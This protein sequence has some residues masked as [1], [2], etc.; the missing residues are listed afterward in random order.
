M[1]IYINKVLTMFWKTKTDII[2]HLTLIILWTINKLWIKFKTHK[3]NNK[4]KI[5]WRKI[6][7]IDLNVEVRVNQI[8]T[9]FYQLSMIIIKK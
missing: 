7:F 9:C 6:Q 1:K 5:I 8:S 2:Q 3:F 4:E